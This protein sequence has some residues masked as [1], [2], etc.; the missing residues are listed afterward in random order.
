ML[1][2]FMLP[3][4][5]PLAGGGANRHRL[6]P[7]LIIAAVCGPLQANCYLVAADPGHECLIIDPGMESAA[8]VRELVSQHR[9]RPVAVLATHGHIDHV[10]DA[11]DVADGY[12]IEVWIHRADRHLLTDPASGLSPDLAGYVAA[13]YPQGLS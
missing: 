5:G 11:A 1:D 8:E 10:A 2:I 6:V 3:Q 12:G 7:M 13:L 9:L 4:A